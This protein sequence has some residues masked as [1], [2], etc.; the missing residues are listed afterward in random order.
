MFGA[1]T[2]ACENSFSCSQRVLSKQRMR[3][4]HRR[5]SS[6]VH[7][8]YESDI[9]NN[10]KLDEFVEVFKIKHPRRLNLLSALHPTGSARSLT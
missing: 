2:A 3:V 1:S 5:K 4:N 9:T 6:L 7:V 8:A 10:I